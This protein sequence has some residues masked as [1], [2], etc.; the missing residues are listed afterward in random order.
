M[1]KERPTYVADQERIIGDAV[2]CFAA[3]MRLISVIDL[4]TYLRM[5]QLDNIESLVRSSAE[6]FFLPGT[7]RFGRSGY[8]DLDWHKAPTVVLNMEFEQSDV[9]S[10]FQ[11]KLSDKFAEVELDYIDFEGDN[12]NSEEHTRSLERAI[13]SA[14]AI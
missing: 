7:L 10:Y 4:I 5:E 9:R 12:D 3:E 2:N 11:L 13:E 6:N 14:L 1:K 8:V